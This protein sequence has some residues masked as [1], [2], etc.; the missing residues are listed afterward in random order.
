MHF[1]NPKINN[2]IDKTFL[3]FQ[4]KKFFIYSWIDFDQAKNKKYIYNF[5]YLRVDADQVQKN[6]YTPS[7]FGLNADLVYLVNFPN[8]PHLET[9]SFLG[10][11]ERTNF[12]PKEKFI[13]YFTVK[14]FFKFKKNFFLIFSRKNYSCL[15]EQK[16]QI[17]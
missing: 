1:P 4:K 15:F 12:L 10:L 17:F 16:K 3:H 13:L 6:S 14:R 7:Y 11:L 2:Y 9:Q 5:S 8:N